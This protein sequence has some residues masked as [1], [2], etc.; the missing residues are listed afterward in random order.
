LDEC[1]ELGIA[2]SVGA[3]QCKEREEKHVMNSEV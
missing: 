3:G 1:V 2:R